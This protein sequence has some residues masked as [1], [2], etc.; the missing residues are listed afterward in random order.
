MLVIQSTQGMVELLY[1]TK[2]LS[3]PLPFLW[4]YG[5]DNN[6]IMVL[7][8]DGLTHFCDQQTDGV[9]VHSEEKNYNPKVTLTLICKERKYLSGQIILQLFNIC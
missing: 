1:L 9:V 5:I 8:T 3:Y 2:L 6:L 4:T 7:I